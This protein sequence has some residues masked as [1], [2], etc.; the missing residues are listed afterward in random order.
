M[1]CKRIFCQ[2]WHDCS[3]VFWSANGGPIMPDTC[4]YSLVLAL[5]LTLAAYASEQSSPTR[6]PAPQYGPPQDLANALAQMARASHV[7]LIAELAQPLPRIPTEEGKPLNADTLNQLVKQSPGYEW[8]MEG[9]VV[10][11]YNKKLRQARFNFLNLKFPRFTIP[12]NLSQFQLWFP[13]RAIGL[14]QGYTGE[15]GV[16]GGFGDPLLEKEALQRETLE[17]VTALGVLIHVANQSPTFYTVLA[18]PSAA[19]T[20][21]EAEK[22][23]SWHFGSLNE[24]LKPIFTQKGRVDKAQAPV[25]GPIME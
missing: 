13:G 14:L 11:F 22:Q 24:K 5:I 12:P 16:S 23:V 3:Y 18:F 21:N 19:P 10:H 15:G 20:K 25:T 17:N 2:G 9:K 7:P 6:K 1:E 4:R 8:K